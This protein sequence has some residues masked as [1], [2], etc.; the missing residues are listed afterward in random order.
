MALSRKDRTKALL[1]LL[2]DNRQ[3][4]EFKSLRV[5]KSVT[6]SWENSPEFM[7]VTYYCVTVTELPPNFVSRQT[8]VD[9][10]FLDRR[11]NQ[12]Q[13]YYYQH[14]MVGLMK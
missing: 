14:C 7:D 3:V 8:F 2:P 5:C 1:P 11:I 12:D 6:I 9:Q 13:D 10:C 4:L